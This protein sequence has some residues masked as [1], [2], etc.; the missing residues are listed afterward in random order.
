MAASRFVLPFAMLVC[1]AGSASGQAPLTVGSITAQPGTAA[2]GDLVVPGRGSEPGTTIPVTLINGSRP[3]PVLALV[4]GVHG[5]EYPPILALQRLRAS[6]DP[7]DLAGSIIMVHVANMPAF[8]GRAIYYT[9]GDRKNLNRVF[10]G[11]ADGTI[12]ERIADVITREVIDRAGF[13][14]DMHGGDGNESLRPYLYWTTTGAPGVVEAGRQLALAFGM[15]HI[16]LDTIRP[17]DAGASIYLSNTAVLRGKPALTIE[18]GY[19]GEVDEDSIARIERGVAGVLRHLK[20]R[21]AG[22]S[23]VSNP[24][25][26]GRNEVLTSGATGLWYPAVE[27]GYTVAEGAVI[28]RVTDFFGRSLEEIRAPFAGEI[29][30]VVGTPPITKGEPVGF[31][32]ARATEAD[33][34]RK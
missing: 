9:P 3:G 12:S 2:S 5:F 14:V 15:D 1:L 32:G 27:K 8:L 16:I 23:P 4:A 33:L 28:G 13:L 31:I 7:K 25:W 34:P 22:P 21:A 10:P 18:S 30:Y 24:V 19:M 11:R 26:I 17:T 20:M 6:I 29:L